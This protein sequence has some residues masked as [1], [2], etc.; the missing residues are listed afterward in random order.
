MKK[1]LGFMGIAILL[2]CA[3][4]VGRTLLNVVPES[5]GNREVEDVA[6][7]EQR[8]LRHM[9]EALQ[10][11]T[12]SYQSQDLPV[13]EFEGFISW[14]VESYPEV[15][16]TMNLTRIGTYTLLY[17]WPGTDPSL[18]PVL[19][20]GHYDVVPVIPGTEDQWT[21]PPYDGVVSDGYV[22]GRGSLDDKGA[23]ITMLEAATQLIQDNYQPERTIYFSFGHD[24]EI[25]GPQGAGGVVEYAK[26]NDIEFLWSLDEGSFLFKD[27]IPGVDQLMG[28]INVAEKGSATLDIVAKA[29]GGHS[30]MPPLDNAVGVLASAIQKLEAEPVP[31]GLDGLSADMFNA[32]SPYMPFMMKMMFSNQWL[33]K[34]LIEQQLF[35][36]TF[37]NA[38]LRTTTAPTMLQASNKVNVLPIEAV[39]TVNFRLH[40]RDTV[41]SVVKHVEQVVDDKRVEVRVRGGRPASEV[42]DAEAIGFEIVELSVREVRP[43]A[44]M[45]PGLMIAGSDSRHYTKVAENAYRFNPMI[46]TSKDLPKIHGTDENITVDN[47]ILA[48]QIYT[49]II[50]NTAP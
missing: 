22:W 13:K 46:V 24:E 2:L 26:A 6:V 50:K 39:A 32:M 23:V 28:S 29:A 30:S 10:F 43:D 27:I 1:A 12:V 42:S 45:T 33:F 11:K 48:T 20:T 8:L 16:E 7:N 34:G 5:A 18:K 40:P 19:M 15:Q 41:E 35:Q 21:H 31:G 36:V 25:G 49:R 3:V 9:S 37:M 17:E 38:S 44:F 14:V 47:L 4:V